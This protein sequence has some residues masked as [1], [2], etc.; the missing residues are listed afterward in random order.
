MSNNYKNDTAPS[1][2]IPEHNQ[3]DEKENDSSGS[4][5]GES[6]MVDLGTKSLS[7]WKLALVMIGLCS[8]VF[9]MALVR[10]FDIYTSKVHWL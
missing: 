1:S 9:C 4:Y 7:G 3:Q 6:S 10:S 5:A 8:A 2:N